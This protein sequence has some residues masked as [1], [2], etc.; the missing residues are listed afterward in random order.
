MVIV[1]TIADDDAPVINTFVSVF[2]VG[3][4]C[5]S[6]SYVAGIM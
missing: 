5:P 6:I 4:I 3:D 2:A 1:P